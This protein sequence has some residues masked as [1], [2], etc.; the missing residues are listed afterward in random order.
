M[1]D[2][3]IDA[4][5]ASKFANPP[6]EDYLKFIKW[7]EFEDE[8]EPQN[9]AFLVVSSMIVTEYFAGCRN[10][11]EGT[12]IT[13]IYDKM[14]K[15]KRLNRKEKNEIDDFI[16]RNFTPK[17]W[18]DLRC[19]RRGSN[20]PKHIAL[21]LLSDRKMALTEDNDL[22]YDLLNFP[23]FKKIIKVARDPINLEYK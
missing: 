9:N 2:I 11:N 8:S 12:S 1:K 5:I 3:F 14:Q 19:K 20:D 16:K 13:A 7:L 22:L 17:I 15:G 23:K 21:I 10:Y 18:N 4:N 6:N